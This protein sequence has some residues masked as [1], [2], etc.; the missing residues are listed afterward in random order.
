[1]TVASY[2]LV[3]IDLVDVEHDV[4]TIVNSCTE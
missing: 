1:M 3:N 4:L 2:S